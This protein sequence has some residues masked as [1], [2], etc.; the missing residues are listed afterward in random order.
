MEN[1]GKIIG[2]LVLGAVVGTACGILLAP[3]KGSETRKKLLN[4]A[5]DLADDLKDKVNNGAGK[6][7]ELKYQAEEHVENLARNAKEKVGQFK[8][9]IG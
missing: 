5:K 8:S 1:T 6:L 4:G 3:D 2:A 9:S 7:K